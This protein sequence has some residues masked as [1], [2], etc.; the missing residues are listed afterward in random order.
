MSNGQSKLFV[1]TLALF[2][3]TASVASP[4]FYVRLL[5][6]DYAV[7]LETMNRCMF[8]ATLRS[9]FPAV[10]PRFDSR[11]TITFGQVSYTHNND[12]IRIICL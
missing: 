5:G 1:T 6:P 12:V 10:I 9:D 7:H 3:R 2:S 4:K 11:S 8:G